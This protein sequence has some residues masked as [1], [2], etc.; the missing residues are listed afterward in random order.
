M[1]VFY[2]V[3]DDSIETGSFAT[4]LAPK[5]LDA[6]RVVSWNI[7]RGCRLND[8]VD[9]LSETKA[10]L[11]LLQEADCNARR[12]RYDNIAAEIARKLRMNYAFGIEF[13]ELSQGSRESPAYHGQA[14][15]SRLPLVDCRILRFEKQ[16]RFWCPYWFLP[17]LAVLQRRLGGR[18]ALITH[19]EWKGR[20]L[21]VYNL[22]LES[23]SAALG[24]AQLVELL[25]DARQYERDTPVI[26]AGDFNLDV[27]ERSFGSMIGIME[28]EDPFAHDHPPTA[29]SRVPGRELAIDSIL[30]R[31][32]VGVS[33]AHVDRSVAASDHFPL[34]LT[35]AVS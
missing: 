15:L 22:H 27:T 35:L 2:S 21:V 32:P 33:A 24:R 14:T 25:Q 7:A 11:I 12:T 28:F 3:S 29:R 23:R 16:S 34:S 20:T 9:F 8:I 31:G 4:E 6:F 5:Q 26:L 13:Q 18:I 17:S 19:V 10:D 1:S 30:I